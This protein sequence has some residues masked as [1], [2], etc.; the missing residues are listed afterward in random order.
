MSLLWTESANGQTM[1]Q[2]TERNGF[3]DSVFQNTEEY[4][5]KQTRWCKMINSDLGSTIIN[6]NIKKNLYCR[7]KT[8]KLF[9]II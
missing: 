6:L 9:T 2:K 1:R 8:N 5:L 3:S 4:I 7:H